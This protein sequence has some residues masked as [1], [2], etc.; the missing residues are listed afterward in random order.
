MS[1]DKPRLIVSTDIG[2]D[3]DD[4]AAIRIAMNSSF[5]ELVGIYTTNG[6]AELRARIAD[7]MRRLDNHGALVAIGE[8]NALGTALPVYTTGLEASMLPPC[9]D[10]ATPKSLGIETDWLGAIS[11]QLSG[12]RKTIIASLAPLTNIARLLG[13]RPERAKNVG[14]LYIM[15]G[16]EGELEHNFSHDSVA[17]KRV[18]ESGLNIIVV[19]AEVCSLYG[20]DL[21]FL[22]SLNGTPGNSLLGRMARLWKLGH[23]AQFFRN[24]ELLRDILRTKA[25]GFFDGDE[26]F[27]KTL[28]HMSSTRRIFSDPDSFLETFGAWMELVSTMEAPVVRQLRGHI[29]ENEMT[30][31]KVSDAVVIYAI[32]HPERIDVERANVSCDDWGRMKL[33][34]GNRHGI[35]RDFDVRHFETYFKRRLVSAH[36]PKSVNRTMERKR[37]VA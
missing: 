30:T 32:E 17:A 16:R 2:T 27:Y 23:D 29:L 20:A 12:F 33:E 19:P 34:K 6:P 7:C 21:S 4:A 3:F 24:S 28:E 14:A 9:M 31:T 18:L 13:E 5:L 1:Q 37:Q 22:T 25:A 15:G 35:V 11:N 26:F 10:E 36:K 8:S